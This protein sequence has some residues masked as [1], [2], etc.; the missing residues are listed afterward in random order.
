MPTKADTI[1]D[2]HHSKATKYYGLFFLLIFAIPISILLYL[3]IDGPLFFTVIMFSILLGVYLVMAYFTF[4]SGSLKYELS[5]K[6]LRIRF[7]LINKKIAYSQ[8][9]SVE[10]VYVSLSLRLFGASLPGVHWGLYRTNIG[11]AHVYGTKISGDYIVLTLNNGQKIAISPQEPDQFLNA[12]NLTKNEFGKIDLN[13]MKREEQFMKK[14]LYIQI[15]SVAL[16]YAV[17]LGYFFWIY[18][19]LPQIV[20]VH[21]G[22][23]GVA[24]RWADKSELLWL[25]GIACAFPIINGV[26]SIKFGKYERGL[27]FLLSIIFVVSAVLFFYALNTIATLA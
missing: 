21:F 25:A 20:P 4:A 17:F 24:N 5:A 18:V 15:L 10:K 2:S 7:G 19:S 8:I 26:L 1:Y 23:D 14:Y 27:L 3:M 11:N 16:V 13:L 9:I 6:E 12:L 22:F